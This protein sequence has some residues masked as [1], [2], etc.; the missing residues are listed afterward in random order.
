MKT[1]CLLLACCLAWTAGHAQND[2]L[3][4]DSLLRSLPEVMVTGERPIVKAEAGRLVFDLPHLLKDRAA[5]N[6]YEALKELPGVTEQDGRLLLNGR[7]VTLMLDGKASAMSASQ[8]VALLQTIPVSRLKDAEVML[9]APAR[10]QVRGQLINLNL[11]RSLADVLQGEAKLFGRQQ[12][13]SK[14][15]AQASLLWQQG[16]WAADAYWRMDGGRA[17]HVMND[18]SRHTLH[19]GSLHQMDSEQRTHASGPVHSYRLA[20]DW[21]PAENHRLSLAYTGNYAKKRNDLSIDGAVKAALRYDGHNLMQ[22]LRMDYATPFQLKAG[23][24][25][26]YYEA[27]M[28]QELA[29]LLPTGRLDYIT[30]NNQRINRWKFF[31]QQEHTLKGGWSLN[32]GISLTTTNDHSWQDYEGSSPSWGRLEGTPH[33]ETITNV[34]AGITKSWGR[35]VSLDLSLAAER[36]HS[37]AFG[38]WAPF[39]NLTLQWLPRSGHVLQLS[40]SSDRSYPEYWAVQQAT[41]YSMGGYGE[42]V[43]N[44]DL[45]PSKSYQLQGLWLLH[46]KYQFVAWFE[47]V[48]DYFVQTNYQR[49]DRLVME[50]RWLNFDYHRQAG[51]MAY[52]PVTLG[53]WLRSSLSAYGVWQHEKDGD[54]YD[55]PFSR[56]VVYGMFQVRNT[57]VL[58]QRLT[59]QLNGSYRTRAIQGIFDLPASGN[60]S[61]ALEWKPLPQRLTLKLYGNDLLETNAIAP[62]M[63]YHT[64]HF[65]MHTSSYREVGLSLTYTFGAYKERRHEAVDTSRF[66][67]E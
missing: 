29:S 18:E 55:L 50:Y 61:A 32:Y 1:I 49:P 3:Q 30:H 7:P 39:P 57:I 5:D 21:M 65:R 60:L 23:V 14:Y 62:E 40:L 4:T 25:Y 66:K 63:H 17:Y 8:L 58:S 35:R 31:A 28:K 10:Y 22:N 9:S 44:P 54:F 42:I 43:G 47:H 36:Y 33:R 2:S 19:D 26:T 16:G 37:E 59:M 53:Q 64:Q 46:N 12:H 67:Q 51:L 24:D 20:A 11:Q 34:Y 27:P 41:N 48:D 15:G 45:R 38:E 56:H 13:D 6:A 52:V